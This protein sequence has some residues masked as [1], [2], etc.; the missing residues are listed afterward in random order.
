MRVV[1][2]DEVCRFLR[3]HGGR[4]YVWTS[5]HRCCSGGLTLLEATT[6][7][8]PGWT[9]ESQPIDAGS[10]ELFLD[11]GTHGLPRDLVLEL[12]GRRRKIRAFWDGCAFI[13]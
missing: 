1:A 13:I 11:T 8:P 5:G 6:K 12:K 4:L 3:D 7:R 10:F 2:S 9:R